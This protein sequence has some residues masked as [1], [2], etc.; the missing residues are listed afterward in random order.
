MRQLF[1]HRPR[2]VHDFLATLY[3]MTGGRSVH[4]IMDTLYINDQLSDDSYRTLLECRS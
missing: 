2:S 1:L 3:I 4:D